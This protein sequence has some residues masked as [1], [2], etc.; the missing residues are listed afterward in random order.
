MLTAVKPASSFEF[1]LITG[2]TLIQRGGQRDGQVLGHPPLHHLGGSRLRSVPFFL[3]SFE[4]VMKVVCLHRFQGRGPA[5]GPRPDAQEDQDRPH[6][7]A[8]D[9]HQGRPTGL[10]RPFSGHQKAGHG[11]GEMR[12][13]GG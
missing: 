12:R 7:G 11:Q 6:N 4:K 5:P 2:R 13:K 8:E 3:V 10:G 9:P 1:I